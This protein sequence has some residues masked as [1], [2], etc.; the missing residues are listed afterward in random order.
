MYLLQLCLGP[1]ALTV[2]TDYAGKFTEIGK[3]ISYAQE[4]AIPT[5]TVLAGTYPAVTVSAT[6]AVA[7][8]GQSKS[9]NEYSQNKV[10]IADGNSALIIAASIDGIEFK[11]INFVNTGSGKAATIAGTKNGFYDCQFISRSGT[12]ISTNPGV[13]VIA[14]SLIQAS[15]IAI[16]GTATLYVFN[17]AIILLKNEG[18]VADTKGSIS[19]GTLFNS[20]TVLDRCTVS[21]QSGNSE[22]QIYLAAAKGPGSVVVFRSS[23]LENSIAGSGVHI[24]DTT[25]DDRNLY[26]EYSNTG[27]GAFANNIDKRSEFVSLL[28]SSDL[29][30]FTISAVFANADPKVAISD[31]YWIDTAVLSAIESADVVA[32]ST[33]PGG[34]T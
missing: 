32:P 21:E 3:A 8:I 17:T 15:D 11:N 30:P 1:T 23:G 33:N 22:G 10:T 31:N 29:A 18:R 26:A 24:D 6:P 28:S 13:A 19:S 4:H 7:V 25:Q 34:G 20:T 2:A 14:N 16:D 27:P 12:G 9:L 5:V